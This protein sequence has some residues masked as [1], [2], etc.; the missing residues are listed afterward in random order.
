MKRWLLLPALLA[1]PTFAQAP[2][3][4]PKAA[5]ELYVQYAQAVREQV[6]TPAS[7]PFSPEAIVMNVGTDAAKLA[8]WV[9]ANIRYEPYI[10]VQRGAEG[11]L[12]AGAGNDWDRAVLM[13]ELLIV[14]GHNPQVMSAARTSEEAAW[15]VDAYLTGRRAAAA[16]AGERPAE[17]AVLKEFGIETKNQAKYAA[18]E[19][20]RV[21]RL[22]T[23]SLDAA[24]GHT[25]FVIQSLGKAPGQPFDAWRASLIKAAG[26]Y[27]A[28]KVGETTLTLSDSPAA[29]AALQAATIPAAATFELKLLMTVADEGK[30]AS[31]PLALLHQKL[32][33]GEMF[34]RPIRFE[35]VPC[36]ETAAAK[37]V[38]TWSKKDWSAHFSRFQQFQAM[39]RCGEEW[40]GSRVFDL[41]GQVL[42]V[43]ADGRVD[44]ARK[45][46]A[47]VGGA[48]GGMMGGGAEKPEAPKSRIESLVLVLT[49]NLPGEAPRVQQRLLYGK[50]RPDVTPL[51]T[52]DIAVAAAASTRHTMTWLMLDAVT[53][54][55]PMAAS[56]LA[57]SD[58]KRFAQT[59]GFR[60]LPL[61]LYDW[62]TMRQT[63]GATLARQ[64]GLKLQ[65]GPSVVMHTVHLVHSGENVSSKHGVDVA[66]D[67]TRLIPTSPDRAEA[68]AKAN[69][70]FGIAATVLESAVLRS[71]KPAAGAG[72]AYTA[73]EE[74]RAAG[75]AARGFASAKDVI[76]ASPSPV[77]AWAMARNEENRAILL[78]GNGANNWW[79]IDPVTGS[80]TGRADSGEGNSAMEYVQITKKNVDNLK[81]MVGMSNQVLGGSSGKEG[82]QQWFLCMTGT[83]N[84]GSGHGIPGGIEGGMDSDL[85]VIESLDIGVGP[86]ADA[87]GGAKDLYDILDQKDPILFTGR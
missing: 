71:I 39:F 67:D 43:A 31:E 33:L 61:M 35:I 49:I 84:P 45:I 56:A 42:S 34:R 14:A 2:K 11:T 58:P 26:D 3:V 8:E 70:T 54:N 6:L 64:P 69:V 82:A 5:G 37:P 15:V 47:G 24:A 41:S 25:P 86:L 53:R 50:D 12:A 74:S 51:Y 21:R 36:D 22:V 28:V 79:S 29:K 68:A 78:P 7:C 59:E 40:D 23:E 77:V 60:R 81:C 27:V 48:F 80:T 75:R 87:L 18:A 30:P 65:S 72:G 73:F 85:K 1:A 4:D 9:K 20:G 16:A 46:G 83:D 32:P 62:Q 66:F 17:P 55:A 38:A 10:G 52:A 63:A 19:Q 44:N 13:R 76:T 57:G